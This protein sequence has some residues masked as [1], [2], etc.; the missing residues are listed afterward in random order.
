[1]S[2]LDVREQLAVIKAIVEART[3]ADVSQREL[4]MKLR[5]GPTFMQRIESGRRDVS[6]R[7]FVRIARALGMDPHDLLDRVL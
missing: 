7:E 6:I 3:E 4:S 2:S 1:M 5:K